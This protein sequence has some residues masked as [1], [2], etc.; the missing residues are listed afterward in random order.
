MHANGGSGGRAKNDN[1]GDYTLAI[2][3]LGSYLK[4]LT[5]GRTHI[6]S[7]FKAKSREVPESSLRQRWDGGVA[8]NDEASAA[9]RNRGEFAGVLPGRTRKWRQ[10]YGMSFDWVLGEC[11]GAGLL[12]V[13]ETGS[14][15]RGVRAL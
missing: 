4:L 13:F 11:V 10:F 7:L 3:G 8:A 5:A 12:E 15:G 6:M 1:T 14:V 2:P 9:R